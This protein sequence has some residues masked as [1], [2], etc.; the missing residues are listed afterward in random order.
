MVLKSTVNY[1]IKEKEW[2]HQNRFNFI[3]HYSILLQAICA[4]CFCALSFHVKIRF[5]PFWKKLH[6][7]PYR[8]FRP[9]QKNQLEFLLYYNRNIFTNFGNN[10]PIL[11]FGPDIVEAMSSTRSTTS[12]KELI[13]HVN[14]QIKLI[15]MR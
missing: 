2:R 14:N 3:F 12:V 9:A 10:T 15:E 11:G 1:K 7:F 8:V 6:F 13:S 5:L 4:F